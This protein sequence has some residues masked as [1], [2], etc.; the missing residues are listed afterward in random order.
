MPLA[1]CVDH[2]YDCNDPA[3][4]G[5]QSTCA[6]Y[7]GK[8]ADM[9]GDTALLVV[10]AII[11]AGM[12]F[13]IG[14]NDSANSWGSSVGSGA[15]PLGLAV[16]L[17]GFFEWLG[18][19]LLGYGVSG[20]I[21]K[22]VADID[23]P[24][25]WG[26]GHCDSG[27]S[28]YAVGMCGSLIAA[29]IFLLLSTFAK[30]PVSTT[31]AIVGAVVGMTVVGSYE[32]NGFSCL[33][34]SF[35]G[36]LSAIIVSWVASPL[37]SG[38]IGICIYKLTERL[39]L[40]SSK[41]TR[42]ALL[43]LPYLYSIATFIIA[44]MIMLKSKPT[45]SIPIMGK[46]IIAVAIGVVM[47]VLATFVVTP[48]V[49]KRLPSSVRDREALEAEEAAR[50]E[51]MTSLPARVRELED[52]LALVSPP[53]SP[54]ESTLPGVAAAED[55]EKVVRMS[56]QEYE[57]L[58]HRAGMKTRME[59]AIDD[60]TSPMRTLLWKWMRIGHVLEH[61]QEDALNVFKYVLV[62]VACLESF[63]HG[64]N[65]T[66]NSTGAFSAVY[67]SYSDGLY[68]CGDAETPWWI[69][70]IAGAFVALG[71]ITL[72]YRVIQTI[73]SDL[74]ELNFHMGFSIEMA[75]TL[76]VVIATIVGLPVSSTHCQVGA[77]V[78]IGLVKDCGKKP[79]EKAEGGGAN[80]KLFGKIALTWVLTLP[81]AALLSAGFVA[82]GRAAINQ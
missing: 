82:I 47:H 1:E 12:C 71:I 32:M 73:G 44:F 36:G 21:Q 4:D 10:S 45:K 63:A 7:N 18:A 58:V 57:D 40:A 31:H 8:Y 72:G 55:E 33:N 62:F 65:D 59:N 22:G 52:R 81:F 76:S 78:F 61:G 56:Q 34:W 60:F 15:I 50:R 5:N 37:L 9:E 26:C 13:C 17:G 53:P 19:T 2:A 74:A 35:D 16:C 3:F 64:A 51:E 14:A 67:L 54:P 48:E 39:T 49:A 43:L 79:E 38:F 46:I 75:S 42:N 6:Y 41:P 27:M 24:E 29:T 66:A 70:S 23:D 30:M 77:V 80:C 68:A 11:G 28:V 20:T 69:M 25:C